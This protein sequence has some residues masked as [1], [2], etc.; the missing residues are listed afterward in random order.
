VAVVP[1]GTLPKLTLDGVTE[2]PA[3]VPVPFNAIVS[4]GLEALLEMTRSPVA[5]AA[6]VGA[7]WI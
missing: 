6:A 2:T 3:A 1:S 4:V 7:N 5:A